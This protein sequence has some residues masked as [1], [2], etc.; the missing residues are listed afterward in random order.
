MDD[1]SEG[2]ALLVTALQAN[3]GIAL[4]IRAGQPRVGPTNG[5]GSA[6]IRGNHTFVTA[7][8]SQLLEDVNAPLVA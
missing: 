1:G 5:H 8:W 2:T 3:E 4:W 6:G 7:L